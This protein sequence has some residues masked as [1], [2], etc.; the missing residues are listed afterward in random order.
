[1]E[2]RQ[3]R[4]FL[5]AYDTGS[6]AA[7]AEK[8]GLSQQAVSKSI[9]R[10]EALLGVRLFERDGRRVR[11]T[12]YAELFL[13]HARTIAAET[14]R[15]RADLGDMMG[16]REGRL[17]IGV[18][19]SAAADVVARAVLLL[20]TDRPN[21]RLNVLAG[22]YEMMVNDLLLGKLD[23]IVAVR[24]VERI[25]PLIR[26]R[27]LGDIPYAILAG[28]RHPLAARKGL[29]LADLQD[30]QWIGGANIGAVEEAI[31]A[32]YRAAG[33]PRPRPEIETTSVIFAQA[34]LDGGTHLAILPEMLM[35]RDLRAGK[36]VTLDID[37]GSWTRPL[38]VATRV[39]APN[40]PVVEAFMTK[41]AEVMR[42]TDSH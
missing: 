10:L 33:V 2:S 42:Q 23:V 12:A 9:L 8:Q 13:P 34:M 3:V 30:A 4:H 26:E 21:V 22:I 31:E 18:G 17:R 38:I 11:P 16:G 25:D 1:M 27:T 19:P 14:D 24:Q 35:A 37:A 7:A 28:A 41:L 40:P 5:A 20:A 32:S 29:T 36:V 15:F 6:F 39:R